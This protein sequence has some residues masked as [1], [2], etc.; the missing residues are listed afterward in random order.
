MNEVRHGTPR[1][2]ITFLS[3]TSGPM[4]SQSLYFR[5]GR[6]AGAAKSETAAVAESDPPI[7]VTPQQAW[8]IGE[9]RIPPSVIL[10]LGPAAP[11]ATAKTRMVT[12]TPAQARALGS[13]LIAAADEAAPPQRRRRRVKRSPE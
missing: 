6:R 11:A 5:R 7:F 10:R 2:T 3:Y 1:S 4:S 12:L 9:S 13:R 8:E